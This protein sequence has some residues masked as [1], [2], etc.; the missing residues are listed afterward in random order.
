MWTDKSR[1]DTLLVLKSTNG[2]TMSDDT[3]KK[4]NLW[5]DTIYK[6]LRILGALAVTLATYSTT[7][8]SYWH[9]GENAPTQQMTRVIVQA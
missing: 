1:D 9:G 2:A 7:A 4:L 6:C 5:L 3:H 8:Q